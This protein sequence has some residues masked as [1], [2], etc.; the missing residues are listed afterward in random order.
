MKR[1]QSVDRRGAS[2]TQNWRAM[3][4]RLHREQNHMGKILAAIPAFIAKHASDPH[5]SAEVDAAET[6]L[7]AGAR[8]A[9]KFTP[10]TTVLGKIC[11]EI[12]VLAK[13]GGR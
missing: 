1:C 5:L 6:A 9:L 2:G 4:A 12:D 3:E 11:T 10:P 8:L 13:A 7:I